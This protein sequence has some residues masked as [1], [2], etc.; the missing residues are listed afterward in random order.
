MLDVEIRD[1]DALGKVSLSALNAY[2]ES[3]GWVRV[4]NWE[5]RMVVWACERGEQREEVLTPL[6]E[7]SSAY[8]NRISELVS[9]LSAWES[10]S[11]LDIYLDL[12]AARADVVRIRSLN[13]A[14]GTGWSLIDGAAVLS[15]SRDL[16]SAAARFAD[17]PGEAVYRWRASGVVANYLQEVRPVFGLRW[18]HDFALHSPV[19]ADHNVQSGFDDSYSAPFSRQVMLALQN[20]LSEASGV[21][22]RVLGGA[23]LSENFEAAVGRG[24]TANLCDALAGLVERTHGVSVG[25]T[26][27]SV[28][29]P[30]EASSREFAFGKSSADV[31]RNGAEWLRRS[32]PYLNA[33]VVGDIVILARDEQE[34]FDGQAVVAYD[35]DGRPVSLHVK[36]DPADHDTVLAAFTEGIPV[37]LDGDIVR[38]GRR[39]HLRE[40]RNVM[41]V[42]SDRR[43]PPVATQGELGF[44]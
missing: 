28:R 18:L 11:Q 8:A 23:D 22:A 9:S 36:F 16:V 6:H 31:L 24:V 32:N 20:G 42:L 14:N 19:P 4:E 30:M 38:E 29:L 27:A 26:W 21:T 13:G 2:L 5:D 17:H 12:V 43:R 7:H 37:S 25:L 41:Q 15:M 1:S 10:R 33:H 3:N 39:Y 34:P 35:L 44:E 40:A